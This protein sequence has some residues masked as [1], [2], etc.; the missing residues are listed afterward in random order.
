M[1]VYRYLESGALKERGFV[2][3]RE[4]FDAAVEDLLEERTAPLDVVTGDEVVFGAVELYGLAGEW[5]RW[6]EQGG[7]HPLDA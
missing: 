1:F 3:A 7:A 2:T 4:A 5:E 6:R